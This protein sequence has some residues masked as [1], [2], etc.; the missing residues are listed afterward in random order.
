MSPAIRS[1]ELG[2]YSPSGSKIAFSGD[3]GAETA[4]S[5]CR[6]FLIIAP[7]LLL[8]LLLFFIARGG[9]KDVVSGRAARQIDDANFMVGVWIDCGHLNE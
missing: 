6:I 5:A 2:G 1:G 7:L 9:A 4:A 3:V 8:L